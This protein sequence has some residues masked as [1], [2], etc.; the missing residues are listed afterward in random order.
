MILEIKTEKH[1]IVEITNK[2]VINIRKIELLIKIPL[3]TPISEISMNNI[4]IF[5][6]VLKFLIFLIIN[7][8]G[9]Q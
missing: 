3:T 4:G 6:D 8:N 5:D 2:D 7:N 1:R 9:E